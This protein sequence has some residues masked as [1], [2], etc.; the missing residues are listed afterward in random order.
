[1]EN[2][3][4]DTYPGGD[5]SGVI[6]KMDADGN[7]LL[8]STY[9]GGNDDDF[10]GAICIDSDG[11]AYAGGVSFGLINNT[12]T[13]DNSSAVIV[14]KLSDWSD[15]DR[16]NMP[17]AWEL[18]YGLDPQ[19]YDGDGDLDSDGLDNS[20]EFALGTDP[21]NADSDGDG[22]SDGFEFEGGFD[23]LNAEIGVMQLLSY[24]LVYIVVAVGVVFLVV[25]YIKKDTL[26]EMYWNR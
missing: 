2:A 17:H 20:Q 16:D 5:T 12:F 15:G 14:V 18:E 7:E 4:N 10:L 1:M 23:P 11:N 19:V 24:N 6:V 9:I 13:V 21:T 3:Y 22:Y 8:Y 26:S 25:L